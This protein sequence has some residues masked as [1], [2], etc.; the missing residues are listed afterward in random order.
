MSRLADAAIVRGTAIRLC[1]W[2]MRFRAGEL[3]IRVVAPRREALLP[4][5]NDRSVAV[6]VGS[7]PYRLLIPGDLELDGEALLVS[8]PLPLRA[9][10][11]VLS[12][13]GSLSGTSRPLLARVQ[14]RHA[15]A[16]C[17]AGNRFGHPHPI[18]CRRVRRARVA[19]WRTDLDGMLRLQAREGEWRVAP[20]RR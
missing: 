17:G 2:G 12:H 18:V 10:A 7:A 19:L 20:T 3:G 4:S 14:P 16:S 9:E 15:F 11:L 6:V 1:E 8:S 5:S 13:H